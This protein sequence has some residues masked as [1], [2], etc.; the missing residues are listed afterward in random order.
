MK[1]EL[2]DRS[3]LLDA[4]DGAIA[5][6]ESLKANPKLIDAAQ[7]LRQIIGEQPPVTPQVVANVSGGVLQGA[8]ADYAVDLYTLDFEDV[9]RDDPES[10]IT[11]EGSEAY[12]GQESAKVDPDFVKHVINA[13][14]LADEQDNE[15]ERCGEDNTG[16]DG[17]AGLCGNCADLEDA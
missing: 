7:V 12:F 4:V 15:C 16:G 11:V 6:S 17:Y 10:V 3:R 14:T 9:P 13:P 5:L 8:S 2:I 1:H